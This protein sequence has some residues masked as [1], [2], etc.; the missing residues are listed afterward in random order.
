[1]AEPSLEEQI[2]R[3]VRDMVAQAEAFHLGRVFCYRCDSSDCPHSAPP[4]PT[5]VFGGYA[6]TGLPRWPEL[7]QLLLDLKHPKVD[8]LYESGTRELAAAYMDGE[9]LKGPQLNV[10]GRHSRA[11]NILGQAVFGF[12]RLY[13]PHQGDQEPV[14]VALT[15]QAV[16]S[17]RLD[18]SPRL[19]LNVLGRLWDDSPVLL[20]LGELHQSRILDIIAETRRGI[21]GIGSSGEMRHGPRQGR[22][23]P[24]AG[25][26]VARALKEMARSVERLGRQA[27]RRTAHAEERRADNRPTFKALEDACTVPEDRLLWDEHKGTVVVIGPRNRVHVFSLDGRHVTS[28]ALEGETIQGRLRRRRWRRLIG[29]PLERFRVAVGRVRG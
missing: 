7:G 21:Q 17:C 19:D 9:Y 16:E 28:L 3:G 23:H 25:M 11:Y 1:M 29:D 24:D 14:R 20:A 6:P 13:P 18:G 4:R 5:S 27:V 22:L 15:V 10:F 12:M 2:R 26:R 8:L